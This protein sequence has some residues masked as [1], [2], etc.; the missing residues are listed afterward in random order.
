MKKIYIEIKWAVIFSI[1]LLSWMLLENTLGWHKERIADQW[2]LTLLFIPFAVFIYLL[3]LREKRRRV[4]DR[5]MTWRQAFLSGVNL[6]V[7]IALLTPI[8][9]YI[10][11]N[12]ITPEFFFNSSEYSTK[13]ERV[14]GDNFNDYLMLTDYLWQSSLGALGF[15]I[16]TSAIVAFFVRKK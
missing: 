11:H 9:S 2:W 7:F 16:A 13:V 5:K 15:G 8:T 14:V 3:A 4:Y 6:T 1:A 10:V 12:Y